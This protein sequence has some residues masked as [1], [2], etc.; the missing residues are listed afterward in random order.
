MSEQIPITKEGLERLKQE[1]DHLLSV[2]RPAVK[3]LIAEAR[4]HGDLRENAEYHAAKE[5][6]SFV[7]GRIQEINARFPK[8]Q[9]VDPA[10][11]PS[12]KVAF[13]AEVHLE[14]QE[15]GDEFF[16]QIVGPDEADLKQNRIS[17][18]TPVGR[19]LIG[20]SEGDL[21]KIPIPKGQLTVAITKIRY[22]PPAK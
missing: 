15:T 16:Y 2:E 21:I 1:M 14:D 18:Q 13:G 20:K 4:E 5:R 8:L 12:D 3:K 17:F 22:P 9:V 19:A 7:E 11:S 6:Q 10:R